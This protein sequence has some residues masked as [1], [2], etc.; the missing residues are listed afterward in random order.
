V[1]RLGLQN[2]LV[3]EGL[4]GL[5]PPEGESSVLGHQIHDGSGWKSPGP[6]P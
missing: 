1:S 4:V 6:I 5:T 2:S 3:G